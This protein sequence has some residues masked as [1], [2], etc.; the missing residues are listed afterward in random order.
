[1]CPYF[2]L[3]GL[4]GAPS[5]KVIWY[6]FTDFMTDFYKKREAEGFEEDDIYEMPNSGYKD[7]INDWIKVNPL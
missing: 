3:N 4:R 1:M 6:K 7:F 2:P 5:G